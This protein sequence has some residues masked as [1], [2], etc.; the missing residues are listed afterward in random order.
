QDRAHEGEERDRE[1]KIVRDDAEELKGEIAEKVRHDHPKLD[2]DEGEEQAGRREAERGRIARHH[3]EDH[4]PEHQGRH[5]LAD[6]GHC[7]GFS[8][9]NSMSRRCS[10]AAMRL[11]SSEI[12]CS[13]IRAKPSGSM[14]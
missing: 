7:S 12:P 6:E 5:V 10:S 11:I 4:G 9:L 3:E 2:A 13:A 1:Q 8:Y 14:S